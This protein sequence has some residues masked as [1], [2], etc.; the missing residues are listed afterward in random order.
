ME[1][2]IMA[3]GW[4]YFTVSA[5]SEEDAEREAERRLAYPLEFNTDN[6]EITRIEKI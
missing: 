1:Y 5:E 6:M 4:I 3:E 2:E